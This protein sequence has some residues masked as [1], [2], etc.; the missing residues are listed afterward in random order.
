MSEE[1][2]PISIKNTSGY[3]QTINVYAD[4]TVNHLKTIISVRNNLQSSSMTFLFNGQKLEDNNE[5]L[6]NLGIKK[7]NQL[8]LV[9]K[10]I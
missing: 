2:F 8:F 6:V 4:Y 5:S 3:E 7:N 10:I 1:A 9:Y